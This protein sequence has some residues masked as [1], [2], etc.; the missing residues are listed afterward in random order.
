M[1]H[2]HEECGVFG[3][4]AEHPYPIA[5]DVYYGLYALQHR[6]QESCGIVVGDDG[7]FFSHKD[8]GEVPT[9]FDRETLGNNTI[10]ARFA[11]R[12]EKKKT[13]M[14]RIAIRSVGH[15]IRA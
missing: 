12:R 9:V 5:K 13:G 14:I 11:R 4:Y 10:L 3:V 15:W 6:G 1:N 2:I 8:L 7:L